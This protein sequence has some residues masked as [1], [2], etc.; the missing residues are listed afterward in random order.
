MLKKHQIEA[1]Y[2]LMKGKDC[3]CSLPTGYGKSLIY[4]LLPFLFEDAF[5]VVIAPL[6]V[7]IEQQVQKLRSKAIAIGNELSENE[8]SLLKS[9][10]YKYLFSHPEQIL[11]KRNVSSVF[12]S[13]LFRQ[14]RVFIVIDE[15][16]CVLDWGESFRSDFRKL[17]Q[18]RS[19]FPSC[20]MLA[21]SA[22]VT[23]KGQQ[24]IGRWLRMPSHES[25]CASPARNNI[26][27]HVYKRP[28]P[29]SKGN[30]VETPYKFI[31]LPVLEQLKIKQ[32]SFPITIIY[33]KTMQWIGFGYE[34]AKQVLKRE[35]YAGE[36]KPE[37]ARV[38]MFHSAMERSSGMV[39]SL[40]LGLQ[41]YSSN[42]D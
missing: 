12:C 2:S 16:H 14:K 24:E 28:S 3:I 9:G 13:D 38:V 31:F 29:T 23:Q 7:I 26:V 35:F 6:N 25:V 5:V 1:I 42:R 17:Y 19:L 22:T 21:L 37:N 11:G 8:L 34:L 41:I 36:E 15:A 27:L 18:L 20:T 32:D 33:C 30:S 4:E 10:N 39:S 40:F